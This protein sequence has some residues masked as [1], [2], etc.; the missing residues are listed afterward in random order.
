MNECFKKKIMAKKHACK[1][2]NANRKNYDVYLKLQTVSTELSEVIIEKK[3]G[4]LLC[5]I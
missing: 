2:F 4:L 3:R 1:S 5:T